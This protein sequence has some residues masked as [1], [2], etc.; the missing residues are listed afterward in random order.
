MSSTKTTTVSYRRHIFF[1]IFAFRK[2][3]YHELVCCRKFK[4]RVVEYSAFA[5][6][7]ETSSSG[8][9]TFIIAFVVEKQSKILWSWLVHYSRVFLLYKVKNEIMISLFYCFYGHYF[10]AKFSKPK[11]III[12]GFAW[13][14]CQVILKG[15]VV[16]QSKFVTR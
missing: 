4:R 6:I 14:T 9:R 5:L 1:L 3:M 16:I 10:M 2:Y 12:S 11:L 15:K 13:I 8:N 7:F